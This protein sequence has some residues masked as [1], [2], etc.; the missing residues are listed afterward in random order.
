MNMVDETMKPVPPITC[1][2]QYAP[3]M[4]GVERSW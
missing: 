1:G 3:F 2:T 4:E